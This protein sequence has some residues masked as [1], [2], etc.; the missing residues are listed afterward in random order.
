MTQEEVLER[1]Q[2]FGETVSNCCQQL[3]IKLKNESEKESERKDEE[4]VE[5]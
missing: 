1:F 3:N 5:I 4:S 2:A